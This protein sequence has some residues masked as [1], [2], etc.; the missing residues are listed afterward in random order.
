MTVI[1]KLSK[2]ETRGRMGYREEGDPEPTRVAFVPFDKV[3]T[4]QPRRDAAGSRLTF[5]DGGGYAV[6]ETVDE[7]MAA[8]TGHVTLLEVRQSV[9]PLQITAV[10]A[11]EPSAA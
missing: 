11:D 6:S 7:I 9:V 5:T 8:L 4:I 2:I 10:S 3:R 1:L